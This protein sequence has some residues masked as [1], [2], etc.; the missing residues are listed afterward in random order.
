M[1][2]A[3]YASLPLHEK[4][5]FSVDWAGESESVNWMHLAREYTEKWHHQQQIRYAVAQ[6]APLMTRELF[7]PMIDTFMRAL[8]YT[9][10]RADT[11]LDAPL[12]TMIRVSVSSEIGGDWCVAKRDAGWV[13]SETSEEVPCN[14]TVIIPP[15][16]AWMLFTKGISAEAAR[17]STLITGD[18]RL[19]TPVF[20]MVAVMA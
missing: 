2:S 13:L 9:Y 3:Y 4:A 19:A 8:P 6:T 12:G 17:R 10:S 20:A 1:T 16:T 7:Y 15:D 18:E 14:A 5:I 11:S